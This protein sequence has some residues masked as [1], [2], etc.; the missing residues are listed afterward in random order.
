MAKSKNRRDDGAAPAEDEQVFA[1]NLTLH[2]LFQKQAA[3]MLD[4]ADLSNEQK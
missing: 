1:R 4:N 3:A 2:E